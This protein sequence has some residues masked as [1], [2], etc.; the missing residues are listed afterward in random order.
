MFIAKKMTLE[1]YPSFVG[2][3]RDFMASWSVLVQDG[4]TESWPRGR[5]T[6]YMVV[7]MALEYAVINERGQIVLTGRSIGELIRAHSDRYTFYYI[8]IK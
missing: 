4:G 8:E 6:I 5:R 2:E 1:N 7:N 3:P